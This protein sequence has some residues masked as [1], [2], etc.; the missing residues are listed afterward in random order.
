MNTTGEQKKGSA[1]QDLWTTRGLL[2]WMVES[3]E[4]K[5]IDS[6][7]IVAEMLLAH[8]LECERMR[9]YMEADRPA[10]PKERQQLRDLVARALRQEPVQYLL[11]EALFF[12]MPLLVTSSTLIPRPSTET[13]VEHVVQDFRA[14]PGP[15]SPLIADIGTGSGCIAVSLATQLSDAR[16]IATDI[17]ESALAIATKN[18]VRHGVEDRV[19]FRTGSLLEPIASMGDSFDAICSNPPYVPDHEWDAIAANVK[20]YEPEAALRGG[21]DGLDLIRPLIRGAGALLKPGG[22]LYLEIATCNRDEV[23][24]LAQLAGSYEDIEVLRDHE[25][26]DRVLAARRVMNS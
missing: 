8:V 9:L 3:F 23:I 25:G 11:Q 21:A 12:G 14:D 13:I 7:R 10:T 17:C 22:R 2:S 6:P 19:E 4:A 18:V 24:K 20:D 16:I 1:G 26:L 15:A 5:G